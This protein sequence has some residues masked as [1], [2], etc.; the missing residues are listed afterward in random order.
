MLP[1]IICY[2]HFGF[3][4]IINWQKLVDIVWKWMWNH[5]SNHAKIEYDAKKNLA[6]LSDCLSQPASQPA[7][8]LLVD[9]Q[10]TQ[11]RQSFY[12]LVQMWSLIRLFQTCKKFSI[13]CRENKTGKALWTTLSKN[14]FSLK[15]YDQ[16]SEAG[17]DSTRT[18]SSSIKVKNCTALK[19]WMMLAL[20][21]L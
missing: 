12:E 16:K 14:I 8:Y 6:P 7:A 3:L 13:L 2:C 17:H 1:G 15:K 11:C 4:M 21:P 20:I 18:S 9:S 10:L 5:L 19:N